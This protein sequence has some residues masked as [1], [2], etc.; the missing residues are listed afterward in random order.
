MQRRMR[1]QTR[2]DVGVGDW[3]R[4]YGEVLEDAVNCVAEAARFTNQ[5]VRQGISGEWEPD[6]NGTP[7]RIDSA[8][9]VTEALGGAAANMGGTEAILPVRPGSWEAERVRQTLHSTVGIHDE[10][11]WQ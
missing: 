2:H 8:A 3:A 5:T 1:Q 9:F 6:P 4:P 10:Y 11:L 7:Q